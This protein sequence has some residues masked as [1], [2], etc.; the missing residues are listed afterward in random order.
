MDLRA[1]LVAVMPN[2]RAGDANQDL[3][4]SEM[5]VS[6]SDPAAFGESTS[7]ATQ[8][9]SIEEDLFSELSQV[10]KYCEATFN[11]LPMDEHRMV[12]LVDAKKSF[13]ELCN[14]PAERPS[15]F[16][17]NQ[18]LPKAQKRLER[19]RFLGFLVWN[20]MMIMG[21]VL[22]VESDITWEPPTPVWFNVV[23]GIALMVWSF[24]TFTLGKVDLDAPIARLNW[25]EA[26][27]LGA[28]RFKTESTFD[29]RQYL[30][31]MHRMIA[32]PATT[33]ASSGEATTTETHTHML[34]MYKLPK[35]F[36]DEDAFWSEG[37]TNTGSELRCDTLCAARSDASTYEQ[38]ARKTDGQKVGREIFV[39]AC[40]RVCVPWCLHMSPLRLMW[41]NGSENDKEPKFA[42]SALEAR[43]LIY[44]FESLPRDDHE[45]I[46]MECLSLAVATCSMVQTP[47]EVSQL[48]RR[49]RGSESRM[50]FVEFLAILCAVALVDCSINKNLSSTRLLPR[51]IANV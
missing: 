41:D 1:S 8:D 13:D 31:D 25:C 44:V 7:T 3:E 14:D 18:V 42:V 9:P 29:R 5:G 34:P 51:V 49:I 11:K 23:A 17:P 40:L 43:R 28:K 38:Y 4:M 22:V 35:L 36:E 19:C 45:T 2:A 39:L 30:G 27:V 32:D 12:L 16:S 10:V 20:F 50:D 21:L 26:C 37:V 15:A 48:L 33:D 6:P 47:T 46:E 24:M